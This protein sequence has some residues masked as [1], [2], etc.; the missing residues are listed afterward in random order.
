MSTTARSQTANRE[1]GDEHPH[2]ESDRVVE[3]RRQ[4]ELV[5]ADRRRGWHVELSVEGAESR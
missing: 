5:P 1:I 4:P 2:R 3:V